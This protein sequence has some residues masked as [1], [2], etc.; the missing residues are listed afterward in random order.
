MEPREIY[1]NA[2]VVL[3]A[4]EIRHPPTPPLSVGIVAKLK[5]LLGDVV[6]LLRQATTTTVEFALP[7]GRANEVTETSPKF[8]SRDSS[9]AV[10]FRQ[11]SLVVET[12]RYDRFERLQELC[13]RAVDAR[14]DVDKIDGIDR[15]GL[16]YIDE[17]RIPD[18][19][20]DVAT[21]RPWIHQ[22]LLG[23]AS[24][25]EEHG[26]AASQLQAVMSFDAAP[27]RSLILRWGPR[28]GYAVDPGGDLKRTTTPPGPYFLLDI[29]SFWVAIDQTPAVDRTWLSATCEDLHRPIRALFE[30]LI[31][32]KLREDVLR[33]VRD[34]K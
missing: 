33:N 19:G 20:V 26:L 31:T 5:H 34:A 8:F 1:P 12:T 3:A 32:D 17:V 4:L 21:W 28:V 27:G 9:T 23:P 22:S 16:R 30:S 24:I 10:T 13:L 2:P 6:P 25:G 29:D 15:V 11:D 14:Q 7:A 18:A